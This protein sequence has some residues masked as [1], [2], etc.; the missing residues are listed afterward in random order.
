M[1]T[2]SYPEVRPA[3]PAVTAA[4]AQHAVQVAQP[5]RGRDHALET[6]DQSALGT[7]HAPAFLETRVSSQR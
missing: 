2:M 5:G 4:S 1:R 3:D 7:R 6:S